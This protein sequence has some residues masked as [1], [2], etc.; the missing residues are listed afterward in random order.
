MTEGIIHVMITGVLWGLIGVMV[1]TVARRKIE[2][3]SFFF[4]TN[5]LAAAGSWVFLVDWP[6]FFEDGV[7]HPLALAFTMT[8][9]S[10]I[11]GTGFLL[12]Q[13]ALRSGHHGVIWT[14]CQS[15]MV[16]PFLACVFIWGEDAGIFGS[17]GVVSILAGM[18][19]LGLGRRSG[20]KE[21]PDGRRGHWFSLSVAIFFIFGISQ[22][23]SAMPSK[24]GYEDSCGLRSAL[25][26]TGAALFWCP[27]F[28][29]RK[30]RLNSAIFKLAFMNSLF[31]L[32]AQ[33][34]IFGAMD[35][36]KP[37]GMV[38][39]VF[40]L[41]IGTSILLFAF[42]SLFFIREK[43]RPAIIM[44]IVMSIAGISLIILKGI[45]G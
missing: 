3:P 15:A 45:S 21:P 27:W 43:V 19:A 11:A 14:V 22:T 7:A 31:A 5:C 13:I 32:I 2:A 9:A 35:I 1:S 17:F 37:F 36:L 23:L 30:R 34:V 42:Y 8:G 24:L 4:L 40:P 44:G 41:A 6:V 38:S 28:L 18:V 29:R 25:Y 10:G 26:L 16:I 12:M 33:A 20:K 39:I